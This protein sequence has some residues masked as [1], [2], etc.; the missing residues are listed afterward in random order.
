MQTVPHSLQSTAPILTIIF[1]LDCECQYVSFCFIS[2]YHNFCTAH[3]HS[4]NHFRSLKAF[5][6]DLL[7]IMDAGDSNKEEA[8]TKVLEGLSAKDRATVE[9]AI[10]A[11]TADQ[12][13]AAA[14]DEAAVTTQPGKVLN[15][16]HKGSL[17]FIT[18]FFPVGLFFLFQGF[19]A[20]PMVDNLKHVLG[21]SNIVFV[22]F[23]LNMIFGTLGSYGVFGTTRFGTNLSTVS[24][25]FLV[26]MFLCAILRHHQIGQTIVPPLLIM[27]VAVAHLF[28]GPPATRNTHRVCQPCSKMFVSVP[29]STE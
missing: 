20:V 23:G 14:I 17:I 3:R 12:D 7:V 21:E 16:V 26:G 15:F 28:S 10:A 1:L 22:L 18:L 9:Q 27:L 29:L 2:S 8:L 6:T 11:V 13:T 5:H 19:G 24:T 25:M 4:S